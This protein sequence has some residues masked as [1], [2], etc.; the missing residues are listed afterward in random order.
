MEA[1]NNYSIKKNYNSFLI[2][3]VFLLFG[4]QFVTPAFSADCPSPD[5]DPCKDIKWE[6]RTFNDHIGLYGDYMDYSGTYEWR[7]CNGIYQIRNFQITATNTGGLWDDQTYLQNHFNGLK[8]FAEIQALNELICNQIGGDENIPDCDH[9]GMIMA[10]TYSASCG[11]WLRCSYS[12]HCKDGSSPFVDITAD[13]P[14]QTGYN[15]PAPRIYNGY[16]MVDVWH[17]EPCGDV[18]C[19]KTF[20]VCRQKNP[21]GTGYQIVINNVNRHVQSGSS[22]SKQNKFTR[23]DLKP[24]DPNYYITCEDGCQGDGN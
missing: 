13:G 10:T 24:G 15:C 1:F 21:S 20:T 5:N 7:L 17:W 16:P 8:E 18:C 2:I 9:G 23:W 6:T 4:F 11:V 22:C 19:E 12:F 3:F 14:S